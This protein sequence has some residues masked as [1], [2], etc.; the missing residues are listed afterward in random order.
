DRQ[1]RGHERV[2]GAED[3]LA[4]DAR[5]VERRQRR[6]APAAG[7]DRPEPVEIGPGRLEALGHLALRPALRGHELVPEPMERGQ[8]ATIETDR[9]LAVVGGGQGSRLGS[10][11]AGAVTARRGQDSASDGAM[12]PRKPVYEEGVT[13]GWRRP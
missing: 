6:A 4:S 10:C 9:E 12:N 8:V 1:R 7:G 5:E 2:G 13:R 3:L 11:A